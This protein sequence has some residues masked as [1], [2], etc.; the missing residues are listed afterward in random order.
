MTRC[1]GP[2]ARRI[3]ILA[4]A[5]ALVLPAPAPAAEDGAAPPGKGPSLLSP[6]GP[7]LLLPQLDSA[8]GRQLFLNK[9][10]VVCHSVNGVGGTMGPPLDASGSPPYVNPFAFAARMWRGAEAMI[11]LQKRDLGFRIELTGDELGDL[12]AFA[13]DRSEQAKLRSEDIPEIVKRWLKEM[14]L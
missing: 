8:R 9:G 5:G 4:V 6:R 1:R 11:A 10:C 12:T 14:S 2:A 13:N 3:A 7:A